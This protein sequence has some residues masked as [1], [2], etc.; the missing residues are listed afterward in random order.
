MG[1][2]H[3]GAVQAKKRELDY[4]LQPAKTA[5]NKKR[6]LLKHVRANPHDEQAARINANVNPNAEVRLTY[7][8]RRLVA[9]AATAAKAAA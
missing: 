3:C 7:K 8:G 4:K 2:K 6:K 9:R 5:K 1:R